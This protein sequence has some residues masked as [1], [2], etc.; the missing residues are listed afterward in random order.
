MRND[1]TSFCHI[2]TGTQKDGEKSSLSVERESQ[3]EFHVA[4]S[5]IRHMYCALLER[6]SRG[7]VFVLPDWGGILKREASEW[8]FM[9]RYMNSDPAQ[10]E[11][12]MKYQ[13]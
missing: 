3:V 1:E 6:E 2:P 11:Q 13:E 5:R 12:H 7:N 10:D 8:A 9:S 4:L